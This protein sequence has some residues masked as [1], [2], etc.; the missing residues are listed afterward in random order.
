M[1][2]LKNGQEGFELVDGPDAGK[3]YRR[4]KSY[5]TVPAGHEHRFEKITPAKIRTTGLPPKGKP[6][7]PSTIVDT[8]AKREED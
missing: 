2:Q 3:S 5:P 7:K 1:Y 4:G 6:S 8:S